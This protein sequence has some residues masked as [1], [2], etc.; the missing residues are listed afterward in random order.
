ML[1]HDETIFQSKRLS[2]EY[3]ATHQEILPEVNHISAELC[4][5]GITAR[6]SWA[7]RSA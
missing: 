4:L 1:M 2:F 7:N 6:K 5:G 3:G